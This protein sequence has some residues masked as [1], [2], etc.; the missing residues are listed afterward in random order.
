MSAAR[1]IVH[2][3]P[4]GAGTTTTAA[5][6]AAHL[7]AQGRTVLL[8]ALSAGHDLEDVLG[9]PVAAGESTELAPGLHARRAAGQA[10]LDRAWPGLAGALASRGARV[11]AADPPPAPGLDA[12]AGALELHRA[13][14]AGEHDVVVVDA[15]PPDAALAVLGVP[16]AV[17]WWL[18]RAVPQATRLAAAAPPL[19]G[20]GLAGPRR[21]IRDALALADLLRDPDVV[22]ARVVAGPGPVAA[23]RARRALTA[24]ALQGV[25]VDAVLRRG[26]GDDFT[27][28][29][30]PVIGVDEGPAEGVEALA[31]LGARAFAGHDAA[32]ALGRAEGESLTVSAEGATLRLPLPYAT[33][34]TVSVRQVGEDVV[35]RVDGERRVLPLPPALG[36]YRPAGAA[37]T[38]GALHVTFTRPDTEADG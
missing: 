31:A 29:G 23:R 7:A 21:A 35:V 6:T 13:I 38:D 9:V 2:T 34:K 33:R 20:T 8:L 3:G 22:S 36:D 25:M 1:T 4:G 24:L 5:A 10:A 28:A 18:A 26:D 14:T 37:F 11:T 16:D 27:P 30:V 32:R 12:P 19:P 17:R 15:G